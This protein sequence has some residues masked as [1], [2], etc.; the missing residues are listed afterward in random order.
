MSRKELEE[1]IDYYLDILNKKSKG[2]YRV[3][4]AYGGWQLV[5]E[6]KFGGIITLTPLLS[7]RELKDVLAS[8][9]KY[10]ENEERVV[11]KLSE[12]I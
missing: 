7:S 2:K 1:Q 12:A 9:V 5:A 10:L 8:I 3:Q 4:G 6:T 11:K